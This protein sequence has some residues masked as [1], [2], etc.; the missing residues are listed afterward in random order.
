[1]E[2]EESSTEEVVQLRGRVASLEKE[3]ASLKHAMQEL[4]SNF[5]KLATSIHPDSHN[6]HIINNNYGEDKTF[7]PSQTDSE[8]GFRDK[9]HT[10]AKGKFYPLD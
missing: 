9:K 4:Q 5:V 7:I 1:M 2:E 3:V 8:E 6:H 10:Q